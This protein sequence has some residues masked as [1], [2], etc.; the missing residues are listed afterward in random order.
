MLI[1]GIM[2]MNITWERFLISCVLFTSTTARKK[3]A[4]LLPFWLIKAALKFI[5][6]LIWQRPRTKP[7]NGA[8]EEET[9][10]AHLNILRNLPKTLL[11]NMESELQSIQAKNF[12]MKVSDWCTLL[13]EEVTMNQFLLTLPM[14]EILTVTSGQLS[15][16]REFA[17]ILED[18]TLKLVYC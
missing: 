7:G 2:N 4:K 5:E 14:R 3:E 12:S 8:A 16:V 10:K 6:L 1:W 17:S 9:L 18:I 13:A 11:M 15:L